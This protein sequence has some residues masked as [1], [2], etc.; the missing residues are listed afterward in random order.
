MDMKRNKLFIM[1]P[2]SILLMSGLFWDSKVKNEQTICKGPYL[3]QKPPGLIPQIFAPGIISTDAAEGCSY[4]STDQRLFIFVRGGSDQN[5]IF[6]MEQRDDLWSKPRLAS[7]S[8]G[9][10]DW[11]FTFAPDDKT[12]IVSSGRPIREGG[13]QVRDYY[14][15]K[16]ERTGDVWSKPMLL[17]PPVNT[18]Q[19]D[20]YPCVTEDGTVIGK[21]DWAWEIFTE[22]IG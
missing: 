12:V 11:D 18:G 15:W 20:S 1:L 10:Y 17:P 8:A 4:F 9:T 16:T 2:F 22:R 7:F 6:I 21:A 19:H 14:L 3:G 13:S 5:G